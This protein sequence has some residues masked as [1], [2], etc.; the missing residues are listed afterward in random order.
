MTIHVE[1]A[2]HPKWCLVCG[3]RPPRII[4]A[5]S[6]PRRHSFFCSTRCAVRAGCEA[7]RA[8][9]VFW[10]GLCDNWHNPD[11]DSTYDG[12]S[13]EGLSRLARAN[14][15]PAIVEPATDPQGT[16]IQADYMATFVSGVIATVLEDIPPQHR[17]LFLTRLAIHVDAIRMLPREAW[18][19]MRR[20]RDAV[21]N[22]P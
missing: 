19:D 9:G 4:R 2:T 22:L 8:A 3:D 11:A 17:S 5:G 7:M 14:P 21:I 18:A 10:C 6:P 16:F 1:S 15:Q 20:V 13:V 12:V